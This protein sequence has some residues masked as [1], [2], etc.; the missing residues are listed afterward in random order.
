MRQFTTDGTDED[1]VR[2][3]SDGCINALRRELMAAM[4]DL[5]QELL[6]EAKQFMLTP[7]GAESLHDEEITDIAN[8]IIV[9]I[10]GGAWA[11]MDEYGTGSL[12][13]ESDENPALN[14]YKNSQLWNPARHG[15]K[16]RS[17]PDSP[18]QVDIFGNPVN[19]KGKGGVDLEAAG[20]VEPQPP[21]HAI[22][23]AARWMANGRFQRKIKNTIH[24]FPFGKY[25]KVD[26]K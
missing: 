16:I 3:D 19:G 8:V 6:A 25:I 23:T 5:Q 15:Y 2:F 13:C 14:D 20:I 1:G 9:A 24:A 22:R 17:R 18:G 7:E 12:M 21:S 11:A 4:K 10:S 26:K